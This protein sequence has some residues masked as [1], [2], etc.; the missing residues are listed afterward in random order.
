MSEIVARM[1]A[2]ALREVP[3]Y[4]S[5]EGWALNLGERYITQPSEL[6][7]AFEDGAM[8]SRCIEA[9]LKV[10]RAETRPPPPKGD[11]E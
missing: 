10:L 9:A 8:P 3:D 7:K 1:I 2:A 6:A 5:Y 11:G 4:Y